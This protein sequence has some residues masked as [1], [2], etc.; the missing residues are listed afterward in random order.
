[1]NGSNLKINES[2]LAPEGRSGRS[3]KDVLALGTLLRL[4][5]RVPADDRVEDK[6]TIFLNSRQDPTE[7]GPAQRIDSNN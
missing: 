2:A 6:G 4:I 5:D 7:V 1:V 3:A